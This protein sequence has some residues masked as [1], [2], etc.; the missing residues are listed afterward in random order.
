M[1]AIHDEEAFRHDEN[2]K[3]F[4]GR[5]LRKIQREYQFYWERRKITICLNTDHTD[6]TV[7][8]RSHTGIMI[9][10]NSNSSLIASYSEKQNTVESELLE[11]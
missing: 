6:N 9:F 7:T 11:P 1:Y 3:D 8:G 2:W 5:C 10:V 4:Y